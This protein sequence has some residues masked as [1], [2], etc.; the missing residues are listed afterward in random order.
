M[1]VGVVEAHRV[2]PRRGVSPVAFRASTQHTM[3]ATP[4]EDDDNPMP[5]ME[6]LSIIFSQELADEIDRQVTEYEF[7]DSMSEWVREAAMFHQNVS[8]FADLARGAEFAP[9]K[10]FLGTTDIEEPRND[11]MRT[12]ITVYDMNIEAANAAVDAGVAESRNEWFRDAAYTYLG[13]QQMSR[14]AGAHQLGIDIE[15]DD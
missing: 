3:N 1:Y 9:I 12:T 5:E 13:I 4:D 15:A 14:A 8:D 10:T 7:A 11:T 6:R 2:H